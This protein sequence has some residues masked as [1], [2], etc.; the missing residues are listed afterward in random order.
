MA[1]HHP[2]LNDWGMEMRGGME[3]W[4]NVKR[5]RPFDQGPAER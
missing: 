5:K 1:Q 3:K 4:V 2:I